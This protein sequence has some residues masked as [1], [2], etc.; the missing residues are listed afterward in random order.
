MTIFKIMT[1]HNNKERFRK[2]FTTT[3]VKCA[4]L[5]AINEAKQ[6]Y[7]KAVKI[8]ATDDNGVVNEIIYKG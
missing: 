5:I 1:K 8:I 6:P 4:N 3:D 7:M 2:C